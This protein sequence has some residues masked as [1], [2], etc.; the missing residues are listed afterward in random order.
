MPLIEEDYGRKLYVGI[1]IQLFSLCKFDKISLTT[2]LIVA[3]NDN[4]TMTKN[5]E[6]HMKIESMKVAIDRIEFLEK[7]N[8]ELKKELEYYRN[9]KMSGRKVHNDK[10]MASYNDFVECFESGMTI[11][12]IA[13]RQRVSERTI[14]RYKAYYDTCA[15][16]GND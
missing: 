14:Y 1:G 15:N 10:W 7:Q 2:R 4:M 8:A 11:V 9:R 12:E 3:Y 5:G 13:K 16:E 6:M